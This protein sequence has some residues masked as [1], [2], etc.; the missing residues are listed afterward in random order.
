MCTDTESS[1][2]LSDGVK[3]KFKKFETFKDKDGK[4]RL[5]AQRGTKESTCQS[6]PSSL[7][8]GEILIYFFFEKKSL[9]FQEKIALFW[10]FFL[11]SFVDY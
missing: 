11:P 5:D 8:P 3:S 6:L 9:V 10:T 7:N 1:C 4:L 2:G